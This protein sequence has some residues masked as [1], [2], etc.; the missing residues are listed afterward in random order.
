MIEIYGD[1]WMHKD[2][3]EYDAICCTINGV[4]K[5]SGELVMGAGIAKGFASEYSWIAKNWG[6]RVGQLKEFQL[7]VTLMAKRPHLVGLPTKYHWKDDSNLP[8]IQKSLIELEDITTRLGWKKVLLPRPGCKNG[9]LEWEQV[10]PLC[11]YY[12]DNRFTV[13]NNGK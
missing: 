9:G 6:G 8:L 10:Q 1:F 5:K 4:V 12:L 3:H 13:I 11:D 2:E 7:F